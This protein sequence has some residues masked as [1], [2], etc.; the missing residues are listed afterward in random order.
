MKEYNTDI[1][2]ERKHFLKKIEKV[3]PEC[4]WDVCVYLKMFITRGKVRVKENIVFHE[5]A[6]LSWINK[7]K[8][9]DKTYFSIIQGNQKKVSPGSNETGIFMTV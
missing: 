2:L 7:A 1:P 9:K 4:R 5:Q 8:D 6:C 3:V